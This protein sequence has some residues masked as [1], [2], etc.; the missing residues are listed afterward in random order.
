M[1]ACVERPTEDKVLSMIP[2]NHTEMLETWEILA[3]YYELSLLAIFIY[4][5]IYL[6]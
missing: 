3:L 2:E 1:T 4:I 6:L 5:Y